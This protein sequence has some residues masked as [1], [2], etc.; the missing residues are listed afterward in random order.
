[1]T[2]PGS[3]TPVCIARVTLGC[4]GAFVKTRVYY[5]TDFKSMR[6]ASSILHS[7]KFTTIARVTLRYTSQSPLPGNKKHSHKSVYS[8]F[9]W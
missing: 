3:R 5:V 2:P 4:E 7:I 6:P 1:M 8:G 9:I